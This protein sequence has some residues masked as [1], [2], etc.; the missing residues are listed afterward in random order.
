MQNLS[1]AQIRKAQ[2]ITGCQGH[3]RVLAITAR[4]P[5]GSSGSSA[6]HQIIGIAPATKKT[7]RN[8]FKM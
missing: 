3:W 4:C 6:L 8:P 7:D 1:G 5:H 2:N